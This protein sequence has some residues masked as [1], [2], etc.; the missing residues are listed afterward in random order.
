MI[1]ARTNESLLVVGLVFGS[2]TACVAENP[3]WDPG[4]TGV[5]GEATA[6]GSTDH[7]E[8]SVAATDE[9]GSGTTDDGDAAYPCPHPGLVECGSDAMVLCVDVM[10]DP[11]HCG[12][13]FSDCAAMGADACRAGVCDCPGGPFNRVCHGVCTDTRDDVFGCGDGCVDCTLA[14][15]RDA[16]CDEGECTD[17]D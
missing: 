13:C 10:N 12:S 6:F 9:Q 16:E 4:T 8:T 1:L 14:F 3:D 11:A 17:D 7:L 5:L 2:T 15:G